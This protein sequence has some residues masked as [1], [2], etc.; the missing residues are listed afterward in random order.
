MF[1]K[2]KDLHGYNSQLSIQRNTQ[3]SK[4]ILSYSSSKEIRIR[5][6]PLTLYMLY[7][8]LTLF[9]D[10]YATIFT[11]ILTF[12]TPVDFTTSLWNA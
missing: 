3:R 9:T 4:I 2:D 8:S 10:L 1:V 6:W 7:A 5:T 12:F 11:E